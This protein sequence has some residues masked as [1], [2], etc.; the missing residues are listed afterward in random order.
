MPNHTY[1]D[2]TVLILAGG[3]GVRM[4]GTD[5]G[6]I[7]CAGRPLIEHTLEIIA[8]LTESILISANRNME[9]YAAYGYPVLNDH[10]ADYP[11]P[12][13]GIERGLEACTTDY[14]WILPCDAPAFTGDLLDRLM[15]AFDD[16]GIPAAVPD[17]GEYLHATFALLRTDVIDSLRSFLS[18]G[19]R[20]VQTWL[21]ALPA[22]RVDCSDHP[23]WFTNINTQDDL[24]RCEMPMRKPS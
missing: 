10:C 20:K 9:R 14:L 6:L 8:P 19:Q 17:D 21:T 1:S 18:S 24:G 16:V 11:G 4:G 2:L 5:K 23:E 7:Q 22:A 12:L 15:Q 13:A 3:Q